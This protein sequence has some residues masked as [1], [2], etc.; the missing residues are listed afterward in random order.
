EAGCGGIDMNMGSFSFI[1]GDQIVETL[2]A[3]AANAKG[4]AF[5]VALNAVAPDLAGWIEVFQKKMQSLNQYLGNSCQLA[6]GIV[7]NTQTSIKAFMDG[8]ENAFANRRGVGDAFQTWTTKDWK[9]KDK[10]ENPLTKDYI[11][12]MRGNLVYK[13]LNTSGTRSA[14]KYG[15]RDLLETIVSLTGSIVISKELADT[16][17]SNIT[18]A[19]NPASQTS[20]IDRL[21]PLISLE[22]FVFGGV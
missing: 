22:D 17:Q 10:L 20:P 1:N 14:F 7:T 5:Q 11:E 15:D 18:G 13:V 19:K 2:R 6:S 9:P 12:N 8:E 21:P 4:Y 3:V 16:E